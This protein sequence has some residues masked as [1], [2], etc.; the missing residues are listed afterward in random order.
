M[1]M[2]GFI[3]VVKCQSSYYILPYLNLSRKSSIE[4]LRM[5]VGVLKSLMLEV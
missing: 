5:I 2:R 1:K 3:S 4:R